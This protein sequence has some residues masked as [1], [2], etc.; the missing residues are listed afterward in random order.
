MSDVET[1]APDAPKKKGLPVGALLGAL[2]PVA[3]GGLAAGLAFFLTPAPQ[4]CAAVAAGHGDGEHAD[5]PPMLGDDHAEKKESHGKK[6]GEKSSGH[7]DAGA[8][9]AA[10]VPMDPLV[11][12]LGPEAAAKYLK[13]TMTIE[14]EKGS[15][16][17]VAALMPRLRD[18]V[19]GYLRAVDEADLAE[20]ASMSRVRAQLL[21]RL[22]LVA[23]DARITNILIT[24]FV[25]T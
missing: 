1:P 15:E 13:I 16:T 7:G 18:V 11:V 10:F 19:N 20:P 9:D 4:T 6:K 12:T 22:Q 17:A 24:D 21:R 2:V 25:L 5:E 23:P 8:A 3:M 14:T